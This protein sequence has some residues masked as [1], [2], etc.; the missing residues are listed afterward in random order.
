M[1]FP[2]FL[3]VPCKTW[4]G[5]VNLVRIFVFLV[6]RIHSRTEYCLSFL[7]QILS[8]LN[9]R[10][11]VNWLHI[12]RDKRTRR[13]RPELTHCPV[14]TDQ[15]DSVLN[16][17]EEC[18]DKEFLV[19]MDQYNIEIWSKSSRLLPF[20]SPTFQAQC[21]EFS[22][23]YRRQCFNLQNSTAPS[24]SRGRSPW[25]RRVLSRFDTA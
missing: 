19:L 17:L 2:R 10:W 9:L 3:L 15:W 12:R 6:Q 11:S 8:S 16:D 1:S 20:Y 25:R 5:K 22:N 13:N 18:G 21:R 4:C 23:S 14:D 24:S 7:A